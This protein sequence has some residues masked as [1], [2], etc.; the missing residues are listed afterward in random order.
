MYLFYVDE[1]GDLGPIPI[2]PSPNGNDQPV[3]VIGALIVEASRLEAV[4]LD[5]L[6]LKR[7]FY[8]GLPY[9]SPNHLDKIIPEIKGADIRRQATRGRRNAQR[10]AIGFLDK[11]LAMLGAHGVQLLCR[12]WVKAPGALMNGRAIYTSSV[13]WMYSSFENYLAGQDSVGF[14]IADSRDHLKNVSVA[15]SIFTQKFRASSGTYSR[16]LELPTFGHSEN[17]AG[18]QL[19]DI[20]CSALL[21]PMAAEVYCTGHIANIHVQPGAAALRQRFGPILKQMQFRYREPLGK[22]NGGIVVSDPIGQRNA[23]LLFH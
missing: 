23:S 13:Q 6:N 20:V 8:P 2:T 18:L 10:H 12:I 5:F 15:H 3:L 9:P 4:T 1:S 16:M 22:W 14:C 7:R 17:H 19:C 21:Y 11:I